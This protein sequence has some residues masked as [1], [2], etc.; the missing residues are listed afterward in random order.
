VSLPVIGSGFASFRVLGS[1]II[2]SLARVSDNKYLRT[3]NLSRSSSVSAT[4]PAEVLGW[5]TPPLVRYAVDYFA[6]E[7]FFSNPVIAPI[8][9]QP[10]QNLPLYELTITLRG[11]KP[12]IWR[13]VQVP[14]S[15][16]LNRL[17]DVFQVVMGWTDSHLHQFV[18]AP[19]VYS[20]PSGDDYPGEERLD[21]RR[22]RLADVARHEKASFM[23]EYDFG[24]SWAHEVVVEKIL[25]ADPKKKYAVC[26]DGKN[27]CPPERLWRHLGLL[28]T[29][30]GCQKSQAQRTPGDARLA[31]RPV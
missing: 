27:A 29:L 6:V 23:Y 12:A 24:D 14:G 5:K 4:H 3:E 1:R 18:D 22:F 25:P 11:S 21:E 7:T 16:N 17:H 10:A 30:E 15:I 9:K 28:R 8:K 26:L 13:C 31:R 20:V 19:I 2:R